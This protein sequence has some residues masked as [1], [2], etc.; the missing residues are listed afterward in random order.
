VTDEIDAN[1]ARVSTLIAENITASTMNVSTLNFQNS[2]V[3]GMYVSSIRGNSAFFSSLTI[4]SDLSGGLGY[5]RF[6]VDASGVQVDGD[7]I[8]FDNLVY[9]TSTINIVQVSTIVD[10]DIFSQNGFFSTL[11]S[12]S[13][14]TG[15]LNVRQAY[16]SSVVCEDISGTNGT[17]DRL[18]VS[19]LEALDI[20]GVD[21]AKNWSLYPTLASSIIFQP[22]NVLSNVGSNLYFAGREL[23]DISGGGASWSV[24]PAFSTV[25]M[26]NN[27][28]VGLS[29]LG[30]QDGGRLT[31]LTGNNLQYNGSNI[32][33]G[34]AGN[35][36]NWAQYPANANVNLNG[37]NLSNAATVTTSNAVILGDNITSG[38]TFTN[39]LGVGGLSLVPVASLTSGGD[40]SVRNIEVGDSVTSLAD[41]NIYGALAAPGDNALFVIGGT[42]LTGGLTLGVPV[43]G[44]EIGAAPVVGVDSMRIDVLPVGIGINA[45]T[46]VQVAAAGAGSFAAGGALSL[47]GGDYIELNTDDCRIINTSQGN[48]ST[49]LTV[50]NIQMPASVSA[51][52]PLQINNTA[53]G[54][55]NLVGT[56]GVGQ[57]AGFSS[58]AGDRILSPFIS[59]LNINVSTING[60]PPGS[61][62]GGASS[63]SSFINLTASN[64]IVSSLT[65]VGGF[66]IG[67]AGS[68]KFETPSG[69]DFVDVI[70]LN[71]DFP[72]VLSLNASTINIGGNNVLMNSVS[73]N[74]LQT[75]AFLTSSF[76]AATFFG[77]NVVVSTLSAEGGLPIKLNNFLQFVGNNGIDN[78][79]VINTNPLNVPV[80][81]IAASTIQLNAA[82][83]T[84]LSLSTTRLSTSAFSFSTA[85][86][87]GSNAGYNIPLLID[88]DHA[89]P[90]GATAN[91]VVAIAVRGHNFLTGAV[92]NQLEMGSRG[93]GENYI[94]SVWPGLNLEDLYIDSTDVIFRDGTFSTI[95]NLDPYG[96]ITT[97]AISAPSLLVS[98]INGGVPG[99]GTVTVPGI[100]TLQLALSTIQMAEQSGIAPAGPSSLMNLGFGYNISTGANG[101]WLENYINTVDNLDFGLE[102]NGDG[103]YIKSWQNGRSSY[104]ELFLTANTMTLGVDV[105]LIVD[106]NNGNDFTEI[107]PTYISTQA[108]A[109]STINDVPF[110]QQPI[111]CEF[112]TTS[113][114]VVG[115]SNQPTV[116]PLDS[117]NIQ[118]GINL[119]AGDVEILTGGTYLYN[120]N[121]Q[122]DKTG[123]GNEFCDLWL[124]INGSDYGG[125]GSRVT[126]QGNTGQCLAVCQFVL[127]LNAND[128]IALVFASP[129]DT[130]A[131][132]YF[133][134]WITPGDP[135]DRPDIPAAIVIVQ[136][137][138]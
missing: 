74:R 61:G 44:T 114:I 8:R 1:V 23:T 123:G 51:S 30:F 70:N 56:S 26:A 112:T 134:A 22:G 72:P 82:N 130:M 62:G 65:Q 105:S 7:P 124:R 45:A 64:I 103:A 69:I 121:V 104:S 133:P 38:Y 25:F 66:P 68:L 19:S 59:T 118:E 111:Y 27:S 129:D 136:K 14:S 2:D 6:H 63:I 86:A 52:V 35:A 24:F 100:S 92:Q 40:L 131:A 96:L 3:S 108:L 126:V 53:G 107:G 138:G 9:L 37:S 20:S 46:Y 81:A 102:G 12:G 21:S 50:A 87:L 110:P 90:G 57:I 94:M 28:M 83:T 17:F 116:I 11:S 115:T 18:F 97:G 91:D 125:T 5:V 109:V 58:I 67:I 135:Y 98:S 76:S 88:H 43:H 15:L 41:V 77:S 84:A 119:D 39:S 120:F 49:T 93:S 32:S 113:T 55:I 99:V 42:T 75:N 89:Q 34:T 29:T 79:D 101:F 71:S 60:Q 47:A 4:A 31:S 137:I 10:T 78:V 85:T 106:D 122:L 36:A 132:T 80:L 95:I 128:K 33:Y 13:L 73:T 127:R 54:G 117:T 48:Q 16:L